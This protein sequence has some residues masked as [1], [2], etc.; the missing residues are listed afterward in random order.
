MPL[1]TKD[2]GEPFTGSVGVRVM[3]EKVP[4]T[5]PVA[6]LLLVALR[7]RPGHQAGKGG[8]ENRIRCGEP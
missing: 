5:D 1:P 6:Q 3:D 2:A 8:Q 7:M 4:N